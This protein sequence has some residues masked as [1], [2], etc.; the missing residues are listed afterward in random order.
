M[1]MT[2]LNR[3]ISFYNSL[4]QACFFVDDF[5]VSQG[6]APLFWFVWVAVSGPVAAHLV[7]RCENLE[8]SLL[9]ENMKN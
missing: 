9:K 8:E 4:G 7:L 6:L 3:L 2:G 1:S 5:K